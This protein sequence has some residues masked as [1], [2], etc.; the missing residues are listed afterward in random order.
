M[1]NIVGFAVKSDM[2]AKQRPVDVPTIENQPTKRG[3]KNERLP[4]PV[5]ERETGCLPED[6]NALNHLQ[7][8]EQQVNFEKIKMDKIKTEKPNEPDFGSEL[9][10]LRAEIEYIKDY[11]T[12]MRTLHDPTKALNRAE[13]VHVLLCSLTNLSTDSGATQIGLKSRAPRG[14]NY[15]VP[16]NVTS[17]RILQLRSSPMQHRGP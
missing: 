17:P 13:I 1:R 16:V 6:A 11:G 8:L 3:F 15:Q 9:Q 10:Y 4:T 5:D 2:N 7:R 12:Q 14:V